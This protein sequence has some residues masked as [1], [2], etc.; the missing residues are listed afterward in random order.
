MSMSKIT[1]T[2]YTKIDIE[3]T[4]FKHLSWDS[5]AE[6]RTLRNKQRNY[7]TFLQIASLRT[8]IN[9][10]KSPHL[11]DHITLGR[12]WCF[13]WEPETEDS[14]KYNNDDLHFL[15]KEAHGVPV[16]KINVSDPD[17]IITDENTIFAKT[18]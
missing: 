7:E 9:I 6:E 12:C 17:V 3:N 13:V 15:K 11:T 5:S 18:N 16:V 4:N 2:C 10:I 14:Y 8:Q 1:V